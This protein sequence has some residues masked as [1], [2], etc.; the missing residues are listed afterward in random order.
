MI[1]VVVVV[2]S[3]ASSEDDTEEGRADGSRALAEGFAIALSIVEDFVGWMR[4]EGEQPWIGPSHESIELVRFDLIDAERGGEVRNVSIPQRLTIVARGPGAA[5]SGAQIEAVIGR[6]AAG[7][8]VP[9]VD[10]LLADAREAMD[11]PSVSAE[12]QKERRDTARAVLL[13][14]IAAE[15][16]IKTTLLEKAPE[17]R[18]S[19]VTIIVSSRRAV[20]QL[21]HKAMKAA[22]GRSLHEDDSELFSAVDTLFHIRNKLA[23]DAQRPTVD[24]ANEAV[25][26]AG[27]LFAWLDSL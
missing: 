27:R 5:A 20:A 17:D 18:R 14:A 10:V 23:H 6:L 26:T 8:A 15:V 4:T 25:A 12:W 11:P 7:D 9:V 13:A 24:E 19:L 2:E 1:Q 16:K 3:S 21:T 22:V